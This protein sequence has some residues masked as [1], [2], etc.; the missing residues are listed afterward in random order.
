MP[1]RHLSRLYL[2]LTTLLLAM[3]HAHPTMAASHADENCPPNYLSCAT[4]S[5]PS[6][7]CPVDYTCGHD[8]SGA[9][10]CCEFRTQCRGIAAAGNTTATSHGSS[11]HDHEDSGTWSV[12]QIAEGSEG[13]VVASGG[14]S[15]VGGFVQ[16]TGDGGGG[17]VGLVRGAWWGLSVVVCGAGWV[18]LR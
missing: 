17:V 18:N 2:L 3:L 7:C 16:S 8:D 1:S 6:V 12:G 11:D 14:G 10:A 4:I 13:G 5:E 15:G 9:V